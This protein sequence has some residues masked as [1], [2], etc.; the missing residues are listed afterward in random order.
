MGS[1]LIFFHCIQNII[2]YQ[3]ALDYAK[4]HNYQKIVELLTKQINQD[5]ERKL[6]KE[7]E[8]KLKKK[9]KAFEQKLESQQ[10]AFEKKKK[11]FDDQMDQMRLVL[12]QNIK[13]QAEFAKQRE[14]STE[15]INNENIKK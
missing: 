12:E 4:Q 13:Q 14:D 8:E 11:E 15:T 6:Q 2:I 1:E 9:Q 10:K 7:F 3:T 5:R